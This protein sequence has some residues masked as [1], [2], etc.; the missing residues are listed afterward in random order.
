MI[1]EITLKSDMELFAA[2]LAG[3]RVTVFADGKIVDY[4][5]NVEEYTSDSVRIGGTWYLRGSFV[6]RV[7][8]SM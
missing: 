6:F 7:Q 3:V 4:G 1:D 5:G 2:A 8:Y